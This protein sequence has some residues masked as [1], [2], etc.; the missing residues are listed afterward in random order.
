MIDTLTI[1]HAAISIFLIIF[2]L[3]QFGKGAEAGIMGGTTEGA[4]FTSSQS[5]NI[6]TKITTVLAIIF[7]GLSLGLAVMRSKGGEKSVFDNQ[8]VA[9]TLPQNQALPINPESETPSDKMADES[10][11]IKKE[12]AP[13][14]GVNNSAP[15]Q[16]DKGQTTKP[17][18]KE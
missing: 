17:I 5:G 2:V 7:L 16:N 8:S 3:L 1:V 13:S 4:V 10:E 9:P 18:D 14:E 15:A 6:L 12:V 11:S